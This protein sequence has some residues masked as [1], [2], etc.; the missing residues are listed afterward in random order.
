MLYQVHPRRA[1]ARRAWASPTRRRQQARR[2]RRPASF[3]QTLLNAKS[4]AYTGNGATRPLIR[5]DVRDH[6]H[7]EGDGGEG[8]PDGTGAGASGCCRGQVGHR[9]FAGQRVRVRAWCVQPAGMLPA[10]YQTYL[11]PRPPI[12]A[13]RPETRRARRRSSSSPTVMRPTR[14]TRRRGWRRS[15]ATPNAGCW[16]FT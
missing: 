15:K 3:K 10:E 7:H 4:V 13:R 8:E 11:G 1:R 14:C 9:D 2:A 12:R 16:A 5:Q 6:G